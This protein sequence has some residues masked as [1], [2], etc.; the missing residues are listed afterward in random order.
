MPRSQ[1]PLVRVVMVAV[2]RSSSSAWTPTS[3]CASTT[4]PTPRIPLVRMH[5]QLRIKQPYPERWSVLMGDVLT[6]LRTALDHTLWEAVLGHSGPLAK[7]QRVQ[8][9]VAT[10]ADKFRQPTI[11]L[12]PLVTPKVWRAAPGALVA[13]RTASSVPPDMPERYRRHRRQAGAERPR[14]SCLLFGARAAA[15]S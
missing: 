10:S 2:M 7:P 14:C 5:W 11:D 3:T 6:N 8:F 9:P 1:N 12:A 4:L 15:F 13:A